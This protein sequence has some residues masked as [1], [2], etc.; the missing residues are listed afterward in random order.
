MPGRSVSTGSGYRYG[1]NGKEQDPEIKG[2]GAQYDYGF[3]IYDPR[4]GRFLSVDPL[5]KTY[6]WYTPYQFAGNMPIWAIDLDGLEEKKVTQEKSNLLQASAIQK[7]M[8]ESEVREDIAN[9]I[10]T[11]INNQIRS[12]EGDPK[13]R[14]KAEET[15]IKSEI[16]KFI[17][18]DLDNSYAAVW[19]PETK[20]PSVVYTFAKS[21]F[22]FAV[23]EA[24]PVAAKAAGAGIY[25]LGGLIKQASVNVESY[26]TNFYKKFF[27]EKYAQAMRINSAAGKATGTALKGLGTLFKA[28]AKGLDIAGTVMMFY[29]VLNAGSP[30]FFSEEDFKKFTREK[31]QTYLEK[32]NIQRGSSGSSANQNST[33][34]SSESTTNE[35]EAENRKR[36]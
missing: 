3:R 4:V 17:A 25:E 15:V 12:R 8:K 20:E 11:S 34:T 5:T 9:K 6:P 31:L 28:T 33:T 7:C 27:P 35:K 18:V 10:Y 36:G 29:D 16:G 30:T 26:K 14:T 21:A 2:T 24:Q 1:F 19:N 23:G 32:Q 13:F 22:Q